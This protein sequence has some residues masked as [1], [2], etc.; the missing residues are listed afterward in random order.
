MNISV[1]KIYTH[2]PGFSC[3]I[4]AIVSDIVSQRQNRSCGCWLLS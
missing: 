2:E 1:V 3:W 4:I